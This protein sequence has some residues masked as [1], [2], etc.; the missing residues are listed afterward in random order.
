ML[1]RLRRR[2]DTVILSFGVK[3]EKKMGKFVMGVELGKFFEI[4]LIQFIK[5]EREREDREREKKKK[6]S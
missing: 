3:V 4:V 6:Y 2:H 5:R 1:V